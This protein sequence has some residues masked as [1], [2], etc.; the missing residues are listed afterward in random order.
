MIDD[1][2]QE[3]RN[4]YM[5]SSIKKLH[6]QK[7]C[8][9]SFA[10]LGNFHVIGL[11]Q[12]DPSVNQ[13]IKDYG[14]NTLNIGFYNER[15]RNGHGGASDDD[16]IFPYNPYLRSL[17]KQCSFKVDFSNDLKVIDFSGI[18][19]K[20]TAA[21]KLPFEINFS[22]NNFGILVSD[23]IESEVAVLPATN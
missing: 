12:E 16:H 3:N 11:R 13:R 5:A 4:A 23:K 19:V 2:A 17:E 6:Q 15:I 9:R 14:L 18:N 22:Q 21:S 10:I 20:A 8:R 1:P 7:A